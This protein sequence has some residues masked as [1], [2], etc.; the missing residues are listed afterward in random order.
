MALNAAWQAFHFLRPI[1]LA[2]LPPLWLAAAWLA[3]RRER[4]G[5]WAGLVD[6]ELFERLRLDGGGA[7]ADRA[8]QAW[9]G[10]WPWLALAW[11][12]AALAL[13]GPS[14]QRDAAPAWRGNAAWVLVLDLSPQMAAT[15]VAPDRATRARYAIDDILAQARDARVGLVVYSGQAY[16]VTPLTDDVNTVRAL[17]PP[18]GPGIMPAGGDALAAGLARAQTLLHGAGAVGGHVIVLT[19]GFDDPAAALAEAAALRK[20]GSSVD[21][22]GIGSVAG[23]PLRGPDGAFE[24]DAQGRPRLARLDPALLQSVATAGGGRYVD[25]AGL[26]SLIASLQQAPTPGA[27]F[28]PQQHEV[29]HWRDGGAW[30]LPPLLLLVAALARRSWL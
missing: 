21:V 7:A 27:A 16:T 8:Q 6:A 25:L 13:A 12:L 9:R 29:A 22:V 15:D 26:P 28:G 19:G 5:D 11:T 2:A 14:W 3:R 23:A 20:A 1:W 24:T 4:E 18:L 10:P 30:L 17:L